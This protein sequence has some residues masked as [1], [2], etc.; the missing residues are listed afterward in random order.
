[1]T[2]PICVGI[3]RGAK[4]FFWNVGGEVYRG[5]SAYLTMGADGFPMGLRWECS[6]SHWEHYRATAYAWVATPERDE[7]DYPEFVRPTVN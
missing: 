6:I 3:C 5:S 1:M 4:A 2:K 7:A